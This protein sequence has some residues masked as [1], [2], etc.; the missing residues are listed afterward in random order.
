MGRALRHRNYRL[1]F[2]GQGVSLIGTWLTQV[3]AS[4]LI[5]RLTNSALLLGL[6]SF[7]SQ[8]PLFFLGPVT[9]VIAD[10]LDRRRVLLFTQVC[11]M[12][13]SAL[14]AYFALR[15]TIGISHI[16]VLNLFQGLVNALDMPARQS[17]LVSL[18]DDRA[19]LPNAVA[20]NS[21]LVN[22]ARLLGPSLGGLLIA[23]V[24][25]GVCFL[26]DAV[27][28]LAVIASLWVMHVAPSPVRSEVHLLKQLREGVVYALG[29]PPIRAVLLLLAAASLLGMPYATLM[30]MIVRTLFHGDAK[31]LGFMMAGSGVGA[32]A[33]ALYLASRSTVVGLGRVIVVGACLFGASLVGLALSRSLIVSGLLITVT[34]FSM[35]IQMASSNTIL[36]TIV[37]EQQRGRVLSLY[38]M[39]A[40]GMAPF[41]SLL[42]GSVADRI[43]AALTLGIAGALCMVSALLFALQLPALRAHV[44]PIYQRLG[45]VPE[46]ADGVASA[47]LPEVPTPP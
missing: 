43:G 32:L 37:D 8:A 40:F 47:S 24:G 18:I 42:A 44:R 27:S 33:A 19:D 34:G 11:S 13:Q 46:L 41:G 39:A 45:I 17:M 5:Y 29:F 7:A 15:G 16:L 12:L 20:L 26:I 25:E 38:S 14:L 1:F 6:A 2:V 3:A 35:M 21:S 22:V 31:L 10:R 9:G 30:P 23:G 36:Q 28:Y 4:W